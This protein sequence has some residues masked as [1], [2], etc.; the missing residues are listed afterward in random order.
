MRAHKVQQNTY[1]EL[2]YQKKKKKDNDLYVLI[3]VRPG[4]Q[5]GKNI[6]AF[7][8]VFLNTSSEC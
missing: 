1:T 7:H 6:N 4:L 3:T 2:V 5:T 8:V